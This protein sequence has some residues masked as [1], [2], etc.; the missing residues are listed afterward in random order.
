MEIDN[1][2]AFEGSRFRKFDVMTRANFVFVLTPS[3]KRLL[4][5]VAPNISWLTPDFIN[6]ISWYEARSYV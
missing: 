3:N 1:R 6:F 2:A 5:D 4:G